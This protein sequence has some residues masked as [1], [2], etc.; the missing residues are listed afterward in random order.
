[1]FRCRWTRDIERWF[2]NEHP[3]PDR[4]RKHTETCPAC[5][6]RLERLQGMRTGVQAAA[7]QDEIAEPQFASFMQGIRDAI[8]TPKGRHRGIWALASLTAAALIVAIAAFM[9]FTNGPSTVEATVVE[10][11]SSEIQGAV[12]ESYSSENGVTTVWLK[13]PADEDDIL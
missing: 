6:Q 10:S 8:E 5:A 9:V 12:V 1:M 2:D 4:V 11:C 3:E 7:K 13:F